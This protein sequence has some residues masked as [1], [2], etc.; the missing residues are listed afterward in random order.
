MHVSTYVCDK[1]R[2]LCILGSHRRPYCAGRGWTRRGAPSTVYTGTCGRLHPSR[3]GYV[4]CGGGRDMA[5]LK[6]HGSGLGR[7]ENGGRIELGLG[8]DARPVSAC[9]GPYSYCSPS[10]R[11]KQFLLLLICSTMTISGASWWLCDSHRP[12]AAIYHSTCQQSAHR[13]NRFSLLRFVMQESW[14]CCQALGRY[15]DTYLSRLVT[16]PGASLPD[17][18]KF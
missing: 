10:D 1:K 15:T 9:Q 5:R 11:I 8:P 3:D 12:S 6:H 2:R 17:M 13:T 16:R 7:R 14:Q 18:V 4:E